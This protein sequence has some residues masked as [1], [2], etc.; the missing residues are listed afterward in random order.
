M[1]NFKMFGMN[2]M[3]VGIIA[4]VLSGVIAAL[5]GGA[6]MVTSV[7]VMVI[8]GLFMSLFLWLSTKLFKIG[9]A[10]YARAVYLIGIVYLVGGILGMIVK[11]LMG[12]S[13]SGMWI[14]AI[15][16]LIVAFVMGMKVYKASFVKILVAYIV[17]IIFEIVAALILGLIFGASIAS[18]LAIV[19]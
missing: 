14:S 8:A 18:Y 16:M 7:I 10:S 12:A 17:A 2:G 13:S 19:H 5:G 1:S 9:G 11:A 4:L 3:L 6:S 15:V